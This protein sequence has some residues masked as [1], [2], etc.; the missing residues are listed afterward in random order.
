M[1]DVTIHLVILTGLIA[2]SFTS[3]AQ[4]NEIPRSCPSVFTM[5]KKGESQ[6]I[7]CASSRPLD[8]PDTSVT[9]LLIYIQGTKRDALGYFEY[10]ENMVKWAHRKKE[11]LVISPQYAN[12]GDLDHYKLA[13]DFLYWKKT[14][15]KDGYT[16]TTEAGRP[17]KIKMSS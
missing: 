12:A 9:T 15:W 3:Q 17:Q 1:R 5:H 13:N 6:A 8:K 7:R 14:A 4:D 10:A 16:S 2:G 11:T